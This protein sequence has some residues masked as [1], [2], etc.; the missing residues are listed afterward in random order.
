MHFV[1]IGPLQPRVSYTYSVRGGGVGAVWSAP[2]SFR[3]VYT[4]ADGGTTRLA[5][6]G[7]MSITQYNAV[8]NLAADCVKGTIDSF[9]MMGV[10][11]HSPPP[12][13]LKSVVCVSFPH[14]PTHTSFSFPLPPFAPAN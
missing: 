6:F 11:Q 10:C 13:V 12:H 3:S 4:A 14:G 2:L 8:G 7:D 5:I 9:W 1:K